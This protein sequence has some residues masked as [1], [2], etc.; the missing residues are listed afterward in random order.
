MNF[1]IFMAPLVFVLFPLA[2]VVTIAWN[3]RDNTATRS[4]MLFTICVF[5]WV[6]SYA[7]ELS[8]TTL[9]EIKVWLRFEYI[10]FQ[11]G[12]ILWLIFVFSYVGLEQ[13]LTRTR[14]ALLTIIPIITLAH[15]FTNDQHHLFWARVGTVEAYGVT[16]FDREYGPAFWLWSLY[17]YFLGAAG[18]VL[19]LRHGI[20]GQT[21]YRGQA[22]WLSIG[23][24]FV[25][26]TSLM[27]ILRLVP[28]PQLDLTPYGAALLCIP[29]S[30]AL[31]RYR[32]L[33]LM[34]AAYAV[35]FQNM[36]DA[37]IVCDDQGRIVDINSAAKQIFA[38]SNVKLGMPV[39]TLL[40][41]SVLGSNPAKSSSGELLLHD[42]AYAVR[43]SPL[44]HGGGNSN[45]CV[46]VLHDVT[47]LK[48][49]QQQALELALEREQM[50]MLHS[51]VTGVTHDIAT[52]ITMMTTSLYLLERT[53][54]DVTSTAN[55]KVS[56]PELERSLGRVHDLQAVTDMLK[57]LTTQISEALQTHHLGGLRIDAVDF[58]AVIQSAAE[59]YQQIACDKGITFTTEFAP[60][61]PPI[62]L[63]EPQFRRALSKLID[64]ALTYTAGGGAVSVR[65]YGEAASLVCE[66]RDTGVGISAS[67]LPYIFEDFFRGEESRPM[68][69]GAGL[70]LGIAQRIIASHGG[71]ITVES[72]PQVGS[73]FRITLPLEREPQPVL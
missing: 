28:V 53:L 38:T 34:P 25:V 57:R 23:V 62:A 6:L 13:H 19:L 22:L 41:S 55:G 70:G 64:N 67:M 18:I 7:L 36:S 20:W 49:M 71:E 11:T 3:H 27:T 10:F 37:V 35:I 60:D 39:K 9:D 66:V 17:S 42:C 46:L 50:E 59:S 2:W 32:L 24:G 30:V 68:T 63:S 58:N 5:L 56:H 72:A 61:L 4:F 12:V 52:P 8:S 51:L 14:I 16:F 47:T 40:P 15:V 48:A 45:G 69:G 73:T 21:L 26:V 33:D 54:T 29:V 44:A 31:F 1:N 65:T 43:F